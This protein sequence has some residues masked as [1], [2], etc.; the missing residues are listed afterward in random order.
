MVT[1]ELHNRFSQNLVEGRHTG[2]G[3][4]R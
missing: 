2:H 1:Q 3:R 4:K